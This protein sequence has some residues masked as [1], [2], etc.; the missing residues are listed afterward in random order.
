VVSNQAHPG[1]ARGFA[2]NGYAVLPN[3]RL[4]AASPDLQEALQP[5]AETA[6]GLHLTNMDGHGPMAL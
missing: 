3:K 6:Q 5:F 2:E 4:F 1:W